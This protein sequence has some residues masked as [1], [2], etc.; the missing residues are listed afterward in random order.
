M[1]LEKPP[2]GINSI[3]INPI[4]GGT[5]TA[6]LAPPWLR[7][8]VQ[9]LTEGYFILRMATAPNSRWFLGASFS[10]RDVFPHERTFKRSAEDKS[11]IIKQLNLNPW[12][13][14]MVTNMNEVLWRETLAKTVEGAAPLVDTGHLTLWCVQQLPFQ[15][16]KGPYVV[17]DGH[18]SRKAQL[19]LGLP[20]VFGWLETMES[21][22]LQVRA[23]H[24]AGRIASWLEMLVDAG[25]I[26]RLD[27]APTLSHGGLIEVVQVDDQWWG[28]I[29]ELKPGE[30]AVDALAR[31]GR[32]EVFLRASSNF[33]EILSW[34]GSLTV[35]TALRLPN[36]DK[37]EIWKR[38]VEKVLFPQKA[39]YFYPKVPFGVLVQDLC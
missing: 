7:D 17:L 34:L 2:A 30:T 1:G 24:R 38:G 13:V 39:T 36:P 21:E 14:H 8:Q 27:T 6:R 16:L 32:G 10:E 31:F 37:Q 11:R 5:G 26:R 9:W 29:T 15:N 3:G 4:K 12:P 22:A 25:Q 20:N 28:E 33:D 23:I 19:Y 35:D 18:H